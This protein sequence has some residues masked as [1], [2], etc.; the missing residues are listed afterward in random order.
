[1]G[2]KFKSQ[3]D[4][5]D[6]G[7]ASTKGKDATKSVGVAG[8]SELG[9]SLLRA[10]K[11]GVK[12]R[13]KMRAAETNDSR[14][15]KSLSA[16][17]GG[18][19]AGN[20]QFGS[21]ALD[22]DVDP[23][24]EGMAYDTDDK[25]LFNVYRDIYN[26][27]PICGSYV[28]MV[29]TLPYDEFSFGGAKDALLEPF[30]ETCDRLRIGSMLPAITADRL[31]T[32]A[33][34]SSMLYNKQK[35]Q[36]LDLWCHRYDNIDV[37]PLPF[38]NQDPILELTIPQDMRNVMLRDS[39]RV[40][41][42]REYIGSD[43]CA[44]I[45]GGEKIELEPL[46]TIWLPRRPFT[47]GPGRS[48]FGRVLP[49]WLIE[50]NL[51]RGTLIESGRRQRGIL[52]AQLGDGADWEASVEEMQYVT[53]LLLA[54]DADPIGAV[55]ATRLGVQINEFRQGGDF[56][57]ITDI[58]DTT[59]QYKLRAL[60]ASEALLSGDATFSNG[61][62]GMMAFMESLAAQR[63]ELTRRLFY[64]KLFPLVSIINGLAVSR[65]GNVIR[66]SGLMSGDAMDVLARVQDGSKLF[67]PSVH[68]AKKLRP[69]SDQ[70]QMEALRAMT[71][72]GVPIPL[73]A[74]AASAGYNLDQLMGDQDENLAMQRKMLDYQRRLAE[75]KKN[76]GP[77]EED[78]AGGGGGGSFSSS[79][80]GGPLLGRKKLSD[81]DFG[82]LG[83]AFERTATGK[84]KYIYNQRGA[85]DKANNAIYK[86]VKNLTANGQNRLASTSSV[87]AT[88][89]R[90]ETLAN[91][92]MY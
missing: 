83:E 18:S 21:V 90:W 24:L 82:S 66:K 76:Y 31:V 7:A 80:L 77:K 50:K 84:K 4:F 16:G 34:V 64:E 11:D 17:G 12:E 62:Q 67:I 58:W 32:G 74:I 68:W 92:R 10:A 79:N 47:T 5:S 89:E 46:G 72:M 56:W 48:I 28:D 23:L 25:H 9:A 45:D 86:S 91:A 22:I 49:V 70:G 61:E 14:K 44:K 2:V 60:G 65:S 81:R 39:P 88:P 52:H 33:H 71:E 30:Y 38:N 40:K 36:F 51:Y 29:S 63:N 27:D 26:F 55:I 37:Y 6:R 53:D 20:M 59:T 41:K 43:L 87:S 85:H 75:L 8:T 73:R 13:A 19:S 54:A 57:K 15:L 1:M 35:A 78:D 3:S 42:L 69:T